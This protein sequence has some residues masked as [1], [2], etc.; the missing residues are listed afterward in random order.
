M[1]T[2]FG[3]L[4]PLALFGALAWGVSWLVER[5]IEEQGA[6]IAAGVIA[7]GFLL[8]ALGAFIEIARRARELLLFRHGLSEHEP[9]DGERYAAIGPI[10]VT[11][12][13]L[14]SPITR[15]PA[16]AYSYEISVGN[17]QWEGLALTS[18]RVQV[19]MHSVRLLALPAFEFPKIRQ[20]GRDAERNAAAFFEETE[21]E[22]LEGTTVRQK[23]E[24]A[25]AVY[26]DTDG[27]VRRDLGSG[28]PANLQGAVMFEQ[29]VE[30]GEE[31]CAIGTWSAAHGG[32]VVDPRALRNSIRL[33]KGRPAGAAGFVFSSAGKLVK[34]TI[35][36][37]VVAIALLVLFTLIPLDAVE[38]R[39]PDFAPSWMEVRIE[40]LI[41]RELHP[42]IAAAGMAV[43]SA[44]TESALEVGRATGRIWSAEAKRWLS[45]ARPQRR[46]TAVC[47]SSC[48]MT[49]EWSAPFSIS[50][51]R[52]V[53]V[54]GVPGHAG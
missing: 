15:K 2:A 12:R 24:A 52:G 36:T 25:N 49:S 34:A 47:G 48:S 35:A 17:R 3:C 4:A 22:E 39:R 50:P 1:K 53:A 30:P 28:K 54:R 21:F 8:V 14:I 13:S 7:A 11:G 31:V 43:V 41:D 38:A 23:L 44:R 16:V 9:V 6:A 51:A 45:R 29:V 20:E 42:R 18:S 5:R 32:L 46:R 40:A 10:D 27:V 19:G 33:R 26:R 37:G